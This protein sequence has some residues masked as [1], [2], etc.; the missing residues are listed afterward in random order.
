MKVILLEFELLALDTQRV[1]RS[2]IDLQR[3]AIVGQR[4][5]S[6][7][8]VKFE[9]TELGLHC[10]ADVQGGLVHAVAA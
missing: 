6:S 9:S 10:L 2:D 5:C 1:A 8:V 7:R 4:L 3:M